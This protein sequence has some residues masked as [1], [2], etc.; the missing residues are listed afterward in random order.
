MKLLKQLL[1]KLVLDNVEQKSQ[2]NREI[3]ERNYSLKTR[4]IE[5]IKNNKSQQLKEISQKKALENK[6]RKE[7]QNSEYERIQE[8]TRQSLAV[9]SQEINMKSSRMKAKFNVIIISS[10][11]EY[12]CGRYRVC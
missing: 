12:L 1:V 9:L 3:L 7:K 4:K 2:E 11:V 8:E 5:K 10:F 6:Q